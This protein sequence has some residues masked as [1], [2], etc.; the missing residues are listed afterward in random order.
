[1]VNEIVLYVLKVERN[2]FC[3]SI[4]GVRLVVVPFICERSG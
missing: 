3:I 2:Y 1:M 4:N